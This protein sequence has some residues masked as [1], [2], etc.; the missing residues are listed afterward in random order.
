MEKI[1]R[2]NSLWTSDSLFCRSLLSIPIEST[3]TP[4]PSSIINSSKYETSSSSGSHSKNKLQNGKSNSYEEV[5]CDD[6]RL[7]EPL[8]SS[9]S[10]SCSPMTLG[11]GSVLRLRK[12]VKENMCHTNQLKE[13]KI[14]RLNGEESSDKHEEESIADF[15]I[16][17][18]SY[19]AKSKNQVDSIN[20]KSRLP[21]A[22]SDD[23]IFKPNGDK[24]SSSSYLKR[25]HSTRN[26]VLNLGRPL[27]ESNDKLQLLN[28]A[29]DRKVA[30]SLRK[31]ERQQ[32]E[33]FQL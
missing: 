4:E 24:S 11:N 10:S 13:E 31:L 16:R 15:L 26:G 23:N 19:I 25:Q 32:D 21:S 3:I 6:V 18:D 30:S 5:N 14:N 27:E 2:A 33:L 12:D 7:E 1:K 9:S 29:H 17:I 8:S 28:M 22:Y 20:R